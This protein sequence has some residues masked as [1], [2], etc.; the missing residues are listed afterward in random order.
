MSITVNS[1]CDVSQ[2]PAYYTPLDQINAQ[3]YARNRLLYEK[4]NAYALAHGGRL[5]NPN[6]PDSKVIGGPI[7]WKDLNTDKSVSYRCVPGLVCREGFPI[8]KT[9][10]ECLSRSRYD[11]DKDI[12][13]LNGFYLQW[14]NNSDGQGVCSLGNK[15]YRESCSTNFEQSEIGEGTLYWDNNSNRCLLTPEYCNAFGKDKYS[16]GD[17]INGYGGKCD[18]GGGKMV[19]EALFG[20]TL[21]TQRLDKLLTGNC[22]SY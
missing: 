8:I 16:P 9:K 2:P 11:K 12:S 19:A 13:F 14:N 3:T 6:D 1:K 7:E 4:T 5:E 20:K 17:Q 15:I 21:T 22:Q 18:I 10:N